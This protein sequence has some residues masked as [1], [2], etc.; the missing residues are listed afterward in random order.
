[1]TAPA[2]VAAGHVYWRSTREPRYA[3]VLA[4]PLYIFY[5]ILVALQPVGPAGSWRN[6][7]DVLLQDLFIAIAGSRGPLLF[8]IA[9]NVAGAVL[10]GHDV[11]RHPGRLRV[12][13]FWLMLAEAVV[14]SFV[15]GVAVGSLTTQLVRPPTGLAIVAG[16]PHSMGMSTRLMLALGAGV[17]EELL[18]RVLLVGAIAWIGRRA[19]HWRPVVAGAVA[20]AL[21]AL[22]F[23]AFHYVG[24]GSD[25]LELYS[26]VFRTLGG[27]FFSALYLLR[28]FGITAWTHALYD[29]L[30][31]VVQA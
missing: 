12:H 17:Y 26:F 27:L 16:I 3:L 5:Q 4:L 18:F 10:I 21:G 29:I 24:P 15:V 20:V 25:R 14:L 19:F 7:A 23:A 9:L 6:G 22:L 1:V 30:V 8:L 2:P 13:Y 28:G 31:M 11:R